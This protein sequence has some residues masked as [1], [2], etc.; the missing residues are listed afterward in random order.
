[1]PMLNEWQSLSLLKY[2]QTIGYMNLMTYVPGAN[3]IE[4]ESMTLCFTDLGGWMLTVIQEHITVIIK[5]KQKV[6]E[7]V[8]KWTYTK[9]I[10]NVNAIKQVLWIIAQWRHL[11]YIDHTNLVPLQHKCDLIDAPCLLPCYFKDTRLLRSSKPTPFL[12]LSL[13]KVEHQLKMWRHDNQ[14][15][16]TFTLYIFIHPSPLPVPSQRPSGLNVRAYT[17][18][19]W[20]ARIFKHSP[21]IKS[22]NRTVQSNDALHGDANLA[23]GNK[24][25]GR[26]TDVAMISTLPVIHGHH[27]I[28]QTSSSWPSKMITQSDS[29]KPGIKSGER[30]PERS[31]TY[32]IH[33]V[34]SSAQEAKRVHDALHLIWLISLSWPL[35]IINSA[36]TPLICKIRTCIKVLMGFRSLTFMMWIFVSAP[37]LAN[38]LSSSQSTSRQQ[39]VRTYEQD[40]RPNANT[41]NLPVWHRYCLWSLLF[42]TFQTHDVPSRLAVN[43]HSLDFENLVA[44]IGPFSP[45]TEESERSNAR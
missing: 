13:W 16:V 33:A 29:D 45:K 19:R 23:K 25:G 26:D 43:S 9:A 17:G 6:E 20:S 36:N 15:K 37:Q 22:H 11:W 42:F 3:V 28:L 12:F 30:P 40:P 21:V 1:M 2:R 18:R 8:H 10:M 27:A 35:Q 4:V 41:T 5:T 31:A 44:K 39:S 14:E 32:H 34:L 24:M 38:I 7:S